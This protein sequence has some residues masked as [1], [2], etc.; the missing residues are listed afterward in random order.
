MLGIVLGI[1]AFAGVFSGLALLNIPRATCTQTE[2]E[3]DFDLVIEHIA[4]DQTETLV[5]TNF[6]VRVSG[7][8]Y[9]ALIDRDGSEGVEEYM[10]KDGVHYEKRM[11]GEWTNKEEPVA[12]LGFIWYMIDSR[13][14]YMQFPSVHILCPIEGED[15]R[16]E[17]FWFD[18]T[19][20]GPVYSGGSD[21][22][23]NPWIAPAF[24]AELP[25]IKARWEYWPNM[26]GHLYKSVQFFDVIGGERKT[27]ITTNISDLGVPNVI[28]A[29]VV[30]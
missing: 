21:W 28:T 3:Q 22:E 19:I 25:D 27:K 1:L 15:F 6:E 10:V 7:E 12:G 2:D 18:E 20:P 16:A 23:S 5:T 4:A 14:H 30:H 9:H 24:A 8:D 17:K 29:P 13:P 11:G 26:D